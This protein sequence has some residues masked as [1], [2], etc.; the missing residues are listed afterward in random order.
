MNSTG[1]KS[2]S[3][4]SIIECVFCV[5]VVAI[6]FLML[7]IYMQNRQ[8]NLYKKAHDLSVQ[9]SLLKRELILRKNTINKVSSLNNLEPFAEKCGL[10]LNNV[11][12]KVQ[13]RGI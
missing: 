2:V 7:P 6:V 13:M 1:K 10:G 11:P 9:K 5:I 8:A 12:I 4:R 3:N